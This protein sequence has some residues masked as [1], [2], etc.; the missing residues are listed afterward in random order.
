LSLIQLLLLA[1][2]VMVLYIYSTLSYSSPLVPY[3]GNK[4]MPCGCYTGGLEFRAFFHLLMLSSQ[5]S[6]GSPPHLCCTTSHVL[7]RTMLS[8]PRSCLT[9]EANLSVRASRGK[10]LPEYGSNR[11]STIRSRSC[12]FSNSLI[13][14]SGS[15]GSGLAATKAQ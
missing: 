14:R 10:N 12:S 7:C 1:Q 4:V 11:S 3:V 2:G 13:V 9:S 5:L 6:K 15:S 8:T